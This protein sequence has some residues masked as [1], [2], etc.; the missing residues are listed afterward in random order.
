MI[1]L[2][3]NGPLFVLVGDPFLCEEKRNEILLS[4]KKELRVSD[5]PLKAGRAGEVPVAEL[6][7][8]ARTL[9]FLAEAQVFSIRD[10]DQ[11]T[12]NDLELW[13]AYFR[14]PHPR[15]FF[16]WEAES[17][18][19]GHPFLELARRR[20]QAFLLRFQR[21]RIAS[22][23]IRRKL[24]QAG[25]K[26]TAEA[27]GLLLTRVGDSFIFLDSILDQLILYTGERPEIDRS[28]VEAFEEKWARLEGFDLLDALGQ[29]D[30]AKAIEILNELLELSGQDATSLVGLFHWQLRRFWE[31]RRWLEEGVPE[32]EIALRL[33]LY[34]GKE[35]LFFKQAR[36][37]SV[38]EL[39]RIL[40]GLFELDGRL[41]TGK[42]EGRY[43][44]EDWLARAISTE[45]KVR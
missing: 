24:K 31:A 42:A 11:F 28:A 18:D 30:L 7:S 44:I 43:E 16:I 15:S 27:E 1:S 9:P 20:G 37:F 29:K 21:E 19:R 17:L 13:E 33:K 10:A 36:R 8:E 14:S 3:L 34:S 23:F 5:L 12:K 40:E 45:E 25:K 41:K 6:L 22:D 39:E 35:A 26:I 38:E 4:L 2:A 32:R